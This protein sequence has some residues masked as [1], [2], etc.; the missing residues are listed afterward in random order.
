MA[1]QG[2]G[3]SKPS[4]P[5]T[6]PPSRP[7]TGR[8]QRSKSAGFNEQRSNNNTTTSGGPRNPSKK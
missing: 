7:V 8:D 5:S 1:K 6:P 3:G 2:S 4:K